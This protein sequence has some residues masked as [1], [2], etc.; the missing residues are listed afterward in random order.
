MPIHNNGSHNNAFLLFGGNQGNVLDKFKSVLQMLIANN[1]QVLD[2]SPVYKTQ[3]WGFH[4]KVDFFNQVVKIHTHL[5]PHDL[6]KW[7]LQA[8]EKLGRKRSDKKYSSRSIDI[9][10]LFYEDFVFNSKDLIIPHPRLHLRN[11]TLVPLNDIA[12]DWMHPVLKKTVTELLY[13]SKDDLKVT[14]YQK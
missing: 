4:T 7:V 12:P 11:F 6:L 1:M 3:S 10:I 5:A 8:E 9:D 14:L 13:Q 2:I